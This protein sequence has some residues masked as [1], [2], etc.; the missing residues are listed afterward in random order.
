MTPAQGPRGS[1]RPTPTHL[2]ASPRLVSK[3]HP[4]LRTAPALGQTVRRSYPQSCTELCVVV[5]ESWA[6]K[7]TLQRPWPVRNNSHALSSLTQREKGHI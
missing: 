7:A 5:W 4:G 6:V 1:N 3:T 2:T